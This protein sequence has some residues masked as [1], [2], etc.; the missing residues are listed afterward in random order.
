VA[1]Q[2]AAGASGDQ[3]A[4]AVLG[5][6]MLFMVAVAFLSPLV[7]G[8][9]SMLL[10]VPV[11]WAGAPGRLAAANTRANARRLASAVT[12]IV[13]VVTFA[14]TMLFTQGTMRHVAAEQVREGLVADQVVTSAGPGLP[15]ETADRAWAVRAFAQRSAWCARACSTTAPTRCPRRARSA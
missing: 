4:V 12:P 1:A 5:V 15:Y 9:G 2:V 8:A 14:G 13:L 3:A 7:A 11:R 10:G 6:V